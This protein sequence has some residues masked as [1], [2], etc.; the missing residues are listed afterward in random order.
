MGIE[1]SLGR[2]TPD[3]YW[4]ILRLFR[5]WE[6]MNF[7]NVLPLNSEEDLTLGLNAVVTVFKILMLSLSVCFLSEVWPDRGACTEVSPGRSSLPW[8]GL[9]VTLSLTPTW[10]RRRL[11]PPTHPTST[12]WLRVYDVETAKKKHPCEDERGRSQKKEKSFFPAFWG[13]KKKKRSHNFIFT[14]PH[15]ICGQ[16]WFQF[17]DC[18]RSKNFFVPQKLSCE[19]HQR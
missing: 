9:L 2:K 13:K 7:T 10:R 8:P 18:W 15:E 16:S 3:G 4:V 12:P 14:G 1:Q 17:R 6:G 11:R 5:S 19:Y